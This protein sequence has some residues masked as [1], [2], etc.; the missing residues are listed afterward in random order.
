MI[1]EHCRAPWSGCLLGSPWCE[2]ESCPASIAQHNQSLGC[3]RP[4]GGGERGGAFSG[5]MGPCSVCRTSS[6]PVPYS[7]S[8]IHPHRVWMYQSRY[9]GVFLGTL[10]NTWK[11]LL[12]P[13]TLHSPTRGPWGEPSRAQCWGEPWSVVGKAM[14]STGESR[15]QCTLWPISECRLSGVGMRACA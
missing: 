1:A 15:G 4:R 6:R 12:S 14:V 9:G 10:I 3:Y 8:H 2:P 5:Q 11:T 7:C 13:L